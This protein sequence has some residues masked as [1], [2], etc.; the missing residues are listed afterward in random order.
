MQE[1]NTVI[2]LSSSDY[3]VILEDL[4]AF[5]IIDAYEKLVNVSHTRPDAIRFTYTAGWTGEED[6]R[7][8][9]DVINSIAMMA[10][11]MY[12]N[13][14]DSV[15]EKYSVSDNLLKGYRCPIV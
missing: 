14:D 13:P 5:V 8:P 12:T 11:R 2:T 3:I 10:S 7:F 15:D 6:S 1:D 4:S 9:E